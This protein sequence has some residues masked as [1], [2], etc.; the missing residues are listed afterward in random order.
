MKGRKAYWMKS[1]EKDRKP[2]PKLR[3]MLESLCEG[4]EEYW[5]VDETGQRVVN[6]YAL[7]AALERW[8]KQAGRK[9]PSQSTLARNYAGGQDNFSPETAQALSDFFRVPKA[10]VTGDLRISSEAWG[11]DITTSEI[12]WIML[13]RELS[14]EQRN[15]IYSTIK[16]LLP[17]DIP[18]PPVPTGV[19][20]LVKPPR[21]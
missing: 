17:P 9:A 1:K 11:V 4:M 6:I 13:L 19:A 8:A 12:R 10:V 14:P 16:A 3:L 7:S 15:V 20:P 18:S 2:N 21:H 5:R